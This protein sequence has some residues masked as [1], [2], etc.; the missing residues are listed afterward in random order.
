M[1]DPAVFS[2]MRQKYRWKATLTNKQEKTPIPQWLQSDETRA[3]ESVFSE[4]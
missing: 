2:P 3:K 4:E 1:R